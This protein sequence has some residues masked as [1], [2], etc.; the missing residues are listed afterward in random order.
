MDE[1]L[2][3]DPTGAEERRRAGYVALLGLPNVGKSTLMNALVGEKLSIVTPKAQTT[4]QRVTGI[5][6]SEHA[7][8]IFLD[9]PGLLEVRDLFQRSMLGAA[10]E[11][12]EEADVALLVLDGAHTG[13]SG[14]LEPAVRSALAL[15][16][17]PLVAAINKVD[18]ADASRARELAVRVREELGGDPYLVSAL[19]GEGIDELRGALERAL[20]ESPFLY[21]EDEIAS[22]PVRFFV[23]ELVRETVFEQYR[24][25][26]PYSVFCQ[27]EEFREDQEP[28]YIG[29]T[30]YVERKSQQGILVGQGGHGIR[31]LGQASRLKIQ[32]FLGTPVYLDLW[33]KTLGGWRRKRGHLAR[34][35]FHVP[36]EDDAAR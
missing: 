28:V 30:V 13:R 15:T 6:T 2:S 25:E 14:W 35:G 18:V 7:Q 8:M 27:V 17:A 12:A 4:W 32:H 10:L 11:A 1:T 33:V 5:V 22:Q 34:L 23:A 20:P 29:V 36:E 3:P 9:T 19:T 16:G 26:I 21:P 24:Q 31:T